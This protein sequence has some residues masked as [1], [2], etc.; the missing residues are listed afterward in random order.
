MS[1]DILYKSMLGRSAVVMLQKTGLFRLASLFLK[2]GL[3]R[4][5]I[6]G[7]IKKHQIDMQDF[8]GQNYR[9]F[10]EFFSRKRDTVLN[11]RSPKVLM[12][13][14]DGLLSVYSITGD[15]HLDMKG[16][17]Y[18]LTDIIPDPVIAKHFLDGICL[19]FRL[20]ASDYHHFCAFDGAMLSKAHFIPG[21]L[22]SVQPIACEKVPVYRLNRRWWSLLDTDHFG[23]AVQ[24]ELGAMLVGGVH[25]AKESGRLNR[26]DAMGN[27]ELAGS[28]I[29]LLLSSEVRERLTL[30]SR[31]QETL[32]G[33]VEVPVRMGEEIGELTDG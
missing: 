7:Y 18:R 10:A 20:Q 27:F 11:S 1:I 12:S 17:S 22:H 5:M 31:Y 14:C 9:S 16:S 2:T 28:T 24:V 15:M 13:P 6:P 32:M 3:S 8:Q 25:F 23:M 21:Q 29:L 4:K 26:G 19:V 30:Y 33:S